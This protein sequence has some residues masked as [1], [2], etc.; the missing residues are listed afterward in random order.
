MFDKIILTLL[1]TMILLG[2]AMIAVPTPILWGVG[3]LYFIGLFI[4]WQ[5]Q[6]QR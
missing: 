4:A 5:R 3:C 1:V 6:P 2:L